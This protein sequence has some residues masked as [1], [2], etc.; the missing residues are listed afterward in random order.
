M[1]QTRHETIDTYDNNGNLIASESAAYQVSDEEQDRE[2]ARA[3]VTE[4]L[5]LKDDEPTL[6][7]VSRFLKAIALISGD[8][9]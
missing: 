5:S 7:Q 2:H 1:P 4:M 3:T 8:K 9:R 6:P